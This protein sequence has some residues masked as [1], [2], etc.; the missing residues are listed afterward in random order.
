MITI[1]FI[2]GR[3]LCGNVR[4]FLKKC[5]FQGMNIKWIESTGMIERSFSIKGSCEDMTKI[6]KSLQ[7]WID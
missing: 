2:V 3:L 4:D 1:S 6:K 7:E 5:Q